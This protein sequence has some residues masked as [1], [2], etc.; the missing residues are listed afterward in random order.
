MNDPRHWQHWRKRRPPWWPAEEAWPP[1][2]PY[3]LQQMRATRGMFFRR[4]GCFFLVFFLL[5]MGGIAGLIWM[6]A[7]AF[8]II[9]PPGSGLPVYF[10]GI[11][12]IFVLAFAVLFI[13]LRILRG[14]AL[15][16]GDLLEAAGRIA[17]GD[18]SVR[19]DERGPR[20]IRAISR[21]LNDMAARLAA[22]QE[23]RR[24]L[25]A[26]VTH[27]LR[28][29]I[30][31]IQGN[32]E[33]M[34]DGI[35]PADAAHLESILDETRVL[36]RVIE[37]LRTL[38]LAES[39]SLKLQRQLADVGELV[40]EVVNLYTP[41]AQAGEINLRMDIAEEL[42]MLE[43][44]P[45]RIREV[46]GN[47]VSNALRYTA[48]GG[49]VC[50]CADRPNP[51]I[52]RVAVLDNG[53]GIAAEDLPHVFDRFYKTGDSHGSG[54]GLAIAKSLVNAH[55]GEITA[56]SEPGKGTQISFHLPVA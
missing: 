12:G 5:L 9:H 30:T 4:F 1:E 7:S 25:L 23:V 2:A 50:V 18:Y 14:T 20:E 21:A 46:L 41:Q 53:R 15:P 48:P 3:N 19:L 38:S 11:V 35:Y 44:D 22:D 52:V 24:N 49:E 56:E 43:I 6:I 17:D 29:P 55:R 40:R 32:L 42:P 10:P 8:G 39:G 16:M 26:D 45:T 51:E 34:L 33:G 37:D 28:T 36:S 47:L 27:E 13:A 31:I 54:L